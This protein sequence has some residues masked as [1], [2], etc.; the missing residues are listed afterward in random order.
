[1][2]QWD[3]LSLFRF[4][5][6]GRRGCGRSGAARIT[7]N[8]HDASG[9]AVS[10]VIVWIGSNEAGMGSN[11]T[12]R[13]AISGSEVMNDPGRKED[14]ARRKCLIKCLMCLISVSLAW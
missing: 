6:Q 5:I 9:Q 3:I 4:A 2:S 8:Q 1:M 10:G 7:Y 14:H 13:Q 11:E 12:I